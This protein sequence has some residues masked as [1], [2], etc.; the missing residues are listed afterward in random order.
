MK[1]IK[2]CSTEYLTKAHQNH[3]INRLCKHQQALK[4]PAEFRELWNL[5]LIQQKNI[6]CSTITMQVL[7]LGL[8]TS[9]KRHHIDVFL[10]QT[11][12]GGQNTTQNFRKARVCLRGTVPRCCSWHVDKTAHK[13][14]V[15]KLKTHT[16]G[17]AYGD[18]R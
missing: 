4:K 10:G 11:D 17:V 12:T 14:E 1:F 2:L 3:H 7:L 9:R 18:Q 15:S 16:S 5:N 8:G 6:K 13:T